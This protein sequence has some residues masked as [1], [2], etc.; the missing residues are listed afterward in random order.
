[1]C[2]RRKEMGYLPLSSID[3]GIGLNLKNVRWCRGLSQK[4]L[5]KK[6]GL[7]RQQISKYEGGKNRIAASALYKV[8]QILEVPLFFLARLSKKI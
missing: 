6:T 3:V 8:S 4:E 5:G 1:M 2:D 7:T